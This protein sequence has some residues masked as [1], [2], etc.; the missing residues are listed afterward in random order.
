M[1]P[2]PPRGVGEGVGEPGRSEAGLAAPGDF[3]LQNSLLEAGVSPL[4]SPRPNGP[5]GEA[6]RAVLCYHTGAE[7]EASQDEI[8]NPAVSAGGSEHCPRDKQETHPTQQAAGG[9]DIR[10]SRPSACGRYL[11]E[12]IVARSSHPT[13]GK[14]YLCL[15]P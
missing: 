9:P 15:L 1:V 3:H 6:R 11:L 4:L 5:G 12:E 10:P 8:R 7:A 14:L 2:E 13:P